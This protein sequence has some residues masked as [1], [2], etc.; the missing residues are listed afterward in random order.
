ME[1]YPR[2]LREFDPRFSS[3]EGCREYFF[4]LRCGYQASMT[5][6]TISQ[7]TRTQKTTQKNGAIALG[8]PREPGLKQYQTAWTWLRKLTGRVEVDECYLGGLEPVSLQTFPEISC[9]LKYSQ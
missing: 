4:K 5:A 8:L 1:H 9:P 6:G 3:E 2:N 7:D